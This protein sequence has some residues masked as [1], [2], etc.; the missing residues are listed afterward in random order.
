MDINEL[1]RKFIALRDKK[2]ALK[3]RQVEE[4]RPFTEM[5]NR[6]ETLLLEY[7]DDQSLKS[8][9]TEHATVYKGV[10]TSVTVADWDAVLDYIKSEEN[11]SLL[12]HRVSKS[13]VQ[14]MLTN[15]EV[16]PGVNVRQE[17]YTR[18]NRK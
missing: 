8:V 1:T 3:K 12:E 18:V 14:D 13:M 17:A 15:G 11:W 10:R 6:L 2:D 5:L 16:V 4:M 7:L 9:A